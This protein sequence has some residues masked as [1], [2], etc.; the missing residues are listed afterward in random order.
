MNSLK[1]ILLALFLSIFLI[2][3]EQATTTVTTEVNLD[4]L[5]EG[6]IEFSNLHLEPEDQLS[7]EYDVYY[8]YVY[9]RFC[10]ACSGIKEEALSEIELLDNDIVFFVEALYRTDLNENIEIEYLPSIVKVV[11][12]QVDTVTYRGSSVLEVLNGLT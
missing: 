3:C 10:T 5:A 9:S 1:K 2:G 7:Q 8:I 12:N 4:I 6:Y 11:N